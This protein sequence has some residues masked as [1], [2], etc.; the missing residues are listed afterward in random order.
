MWIDHFL[1]IFFV[2]N[3]CFLTQYL[4]AI[5]SVSCCLFSIYLLVQKFCF[6]I[7]FLLLQQSHPKHKSGQTKSKIGI[8][9]F[10]CQIQYHLWRQVMPHETL[11][12]IKIRLSSRLYIQQEFFLLHADHQVVQRTPIFSNI[13]FW[14]IVRSV[15][16]EY[17]V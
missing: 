3:T 12:R 4:F 8:S 2:K 14:K 1:L 6:L 15:A 5:Y 17:P 7:R 16:F 9:Q 13:N 10:G 11:Q